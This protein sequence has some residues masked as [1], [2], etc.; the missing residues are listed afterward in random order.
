M[1]VSDFKGAINCKFPPKTN[2]DEEGT[3]SMESEINMHISYA[4]NKARFFAGREKVSYL[5]HLQIYANLLSM[6]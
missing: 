5:I 6:L 1:I 2:E 4:A 3:N